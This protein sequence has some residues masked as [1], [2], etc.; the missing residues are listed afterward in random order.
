MTKEITTIM[1]YEGKLFKGL[2]IGRV[3]E[4]ETEYMIA[5]T[6]HGGI[7]YRGDWA[8]DKWQFLSEKAFTQRF[9]ELADNTLN[10]AKN[11]TRIKRRLDEE[12]L[13]CF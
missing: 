13:L 6:E 2:I 9:P 12:G 8:N 4:G 1:N 11:L 7:W 3:A 10:N 5:V